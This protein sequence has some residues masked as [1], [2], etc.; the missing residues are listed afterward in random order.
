MSANIECMSVMQIANRLVELCQKGEFEGAVNEL[1]SDAIVSY[2]AQGEVRVAEGIEAIRAKTDWWNNTFEVLKAEVEGPW[3]NEPYFMVKFIIDVK[4]R[5]SGES[6]H[7][8][9]FALYQV[10]GDKIVN[11]RFFG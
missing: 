6:T 9:E 10:E 5:Q 7:M 3:L 4:H 1:Y 11:E 2:E 8:E